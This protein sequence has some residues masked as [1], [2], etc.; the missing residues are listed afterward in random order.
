MKIHGIENLSNSEINAELRR[1]AKFVVFQY[2][3]S[4]I[5]MS[6]KRSSA[7]YFVRAC[8]GTAGRTAGFCGLSLLLGW[9]GIPWGPIWT[10][11]TV[12]KNLGGGVDV[13]ANVL[14]ALNAAAPIPQAPGVQ[15]AA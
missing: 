7:I 3:I 2:C 9:W 14:S 5:V 8:E 6:F 10:L 13:T 1:G 4:I 12:F 15:R 11:G